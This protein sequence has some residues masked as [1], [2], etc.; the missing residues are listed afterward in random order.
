[1][2]RYILVC[3][4]EKRENK[5]VLCLRIKI[6]GAGAL[7]MLFA[8]QLSSTEAQIELLTHTEGQS[9][10]LKRDGLHFI[11]NNK[12]S[13]IP[14]EV[15]SIYSDQCSTDKSDP[16]DWILLMVKQKD[17]TE[18]LIQ[19][20]LLLATKE[21]RL[22]CFQNGIGHKELLDQRFPSNRLYAAI[23]SEAALK[24]S[25]HSVR[26]TGRGTTWLGRMEESSAFSDEFDEKEI[27]LHSLLI[28]AGFEV[29]LSKKMISYIWN[30]LLINAVINPITA[31]M[32]IKNGGLLQSPFLM[33]LM[34][35]LLEEGQLV[36]QKLGI[37]TEANLW[38]QLLLVCERTSENQ[39][40]MMKDI[41]QGKTTE[42]EW[43]NGALIRQADKFKLK[44]PA[45]ETIYRMVKHLESR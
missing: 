30:K 28:K 9:D 41:A 25:M 2:S 44:I 35:S 14:I 6:V 21:T 40:S 43:I 42:I 27:M 11:A 20:L 13:N 39:S 3:Y 1:V 5:E 18:P 36:T 16:V 17:I 29:F 45:H 38:E 12:E 15:S 19:R 24:L 22:L 7:G 8:S 26:H 23:T 10:A 33:E 34:S 31:I 32:Q 37:E 4:I